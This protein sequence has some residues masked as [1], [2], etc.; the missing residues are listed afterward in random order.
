VK[1][2]RLRLA[3]EPSVGEIEAAIG[4]PS[5]YDEV[6]FCGYGEPL[7]RLE[8]VKEVA[9]WVKRRG[10]RVRL[11]TNGHGNLIHGRNILPELEGLVDAVSVSLDAQ[12]AGTYEKL[13]APQFPNAFEEVLAFIREAKGRIPDVQATVVDL[14][15]VDLGKCRELADGLGVKL[16]VRKLHVVG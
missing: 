9:S 15:G 13:C 11:N 10:G 8:E 7:L 1:G 5:S 4:D 16:R 3:G 14:E 12:D 2:H 6:V